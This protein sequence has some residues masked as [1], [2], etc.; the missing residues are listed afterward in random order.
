MR[1]AAHA[2]RGGSSRACA[3]CALGRRWSKPRPP[4]RIGHESPTAASR[5]ASRGGR[6]ARVRNGAEGDGRRPRCLCAH[7]ARKRRRAGL[8]CPGRA[9]VSGQQRWVPEVLPAVMTDTY[10][11][12]LSRVGEDAWGPGGAMRLVPLCPP[13]PRRTGLGCGRGPLLA[14]PLRHPYHCCRASRRAGAAV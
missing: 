7:R 14:V 4:C 12:W 9:D 11:H 5:P 6:G 10:T 13:P 2:A 1:Y 3:N 8:I